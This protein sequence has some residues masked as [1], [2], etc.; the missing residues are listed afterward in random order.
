MS[1]ERWRRLAEYN[2]ER[3]RGIVYVLAFDELMVR[4]QAAFRAEKDAEARE[5]DGMSLPGGG[6]LIIPEEM[7]G[8][9]TEEELADGWVVSMIPDETLYDPLRRP[10]WQWPWWPR[11]RP[12]QY[13]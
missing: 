7:R 8:L 12:E 11:R 6:W 10:W 3:A 2:A 9:V 1:E 13:R 5:L 4:E